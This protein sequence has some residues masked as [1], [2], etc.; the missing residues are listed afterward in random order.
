MN[1]CLKE[2]F[3]EEEKNVG[4]VTDEED[5]NMKFDELFREMKEEIKN[6]SSGHIYKPC[7]FVIS[8]YTLSFVASFPKVSNTS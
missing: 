1:N 5:M 2:G 7:L 3:K 6:E 8:S 4:V